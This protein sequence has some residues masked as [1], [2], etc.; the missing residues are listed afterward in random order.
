MLMSQLK[1]VFLHICV[2]FSSC[3]T[4]VHFLAKDL[5]KQG[6]NVGSTLDDILYV[7]TL[8]NTYNKKIQ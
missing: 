3:D 2:I 4:Y 1:N 5:L 7:I 6:G 8:S